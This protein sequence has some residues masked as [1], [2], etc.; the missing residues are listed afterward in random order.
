MPKIKDLEAISFC[1]LWRIKYLWLLF[2]ESWLVTGKRWSFSVWK[3]QASTPK[4]P[5]PHKTSLWS[6]ILKLPTKGGCH[7]IKWWVESQKHLMYVN[8]SMYAWH[9]MKNTVKHFMYVFY[10]VGKVNW[11][12]NYGVCVCV[13]SLFGHVRLCVTT[14][15]HPARLLC[16]W[17]S[18]SK[19]TGVGSHSFFQGIFQTQG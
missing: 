10:T 8:S 17:D 3:K 16:P 19:I 15:L 6:Y 13:L 5:T 9:V 14:G 18:L 4:S 1:L 7:M 2:T 12:S 11:Y